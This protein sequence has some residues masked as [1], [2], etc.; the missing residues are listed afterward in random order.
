MAMPAAAWA[1]RSGDPILFAAGD[2]VP[3]ATLDVIAEHKDTPIYVL[4]PDATISGKAL[5]Q[6]AKEGTKPV[7]V[8]AEDPVE[9]A[10]EFAR[11]ADGDFGWNINDP[12]HGFTIAN[13]ERP[14][15]AAAGAPLAAGGQPGPLLLTDDADTV[16]AALE[17]FLLDTKPGFVDD[18]ERAIV[19]HVW[20][21]G[22]SAAIS[23]EFQARVDEL[24][25]LAPIERGDGE[26]RFGPAPGSDSD[27]KGDKG[28][29]GDKGDKGDKGGGSGD[30]GGSGGDGGSGGSGGNSDSTGS[31]G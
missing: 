19:N 23:V 6:M 16:P 22:N 27:E 31:D 29:K 21:L 30:G 15:D 28:G 24:T 2:D 3:Q 20:L 8:G 13:A 1:A 18:P 10:I 7:R 5:D 14:V 17:G 12:G 9:N 4:G 26:P 25:A 11:F